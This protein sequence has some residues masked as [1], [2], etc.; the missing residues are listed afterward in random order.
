MQPRTYV[1]RVVIANG[2]SLSGAV[3]VRGYRLVAIQTP[4][5]WTAADL[6]FQATVDED[7]TGTPANYENIYDDNDAELVVQAGVDRFILLSAAKQL[8]GIRWLKVRSGTAGVAV[9]QGGARELWLSFV[10]EH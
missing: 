2:A 3:D 7:A 5:A 10:K 1:K 9:N 6:T 4:S 8:R